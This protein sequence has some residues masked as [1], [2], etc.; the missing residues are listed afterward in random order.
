MEEKDIPIWW[1]RKYIEQFADWQK[2]YFQ[3]MIRDW[4]A[5]NEQKRAKQGK[6][7]GKI[8]GE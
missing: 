2:R 8:H 5:D 6:Y 1:I 4:M 7:E 3:Q